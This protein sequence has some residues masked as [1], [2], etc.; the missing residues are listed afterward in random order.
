MQFRLQKLLTKP[1]YKASCRHQ[2]SVNKI[3]ESQFTK[4]YRAK[5]NLRQTS[6][7]RWSAIVYIYSTCTDFQK[8]I[9]VNSSNRN[10]RIIQVSCDPTYSR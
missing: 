9:P 10:M 8:L 4:C 2:S 5:V 7:Q 3:R 1:F 6:E